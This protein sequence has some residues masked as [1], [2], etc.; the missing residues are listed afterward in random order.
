MDHLVEKMKTTVKRGLILRFVGI[1]GNFIE[2]RMCFQIT[3][4]SSHNIPLYFQK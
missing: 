2:K 1:S 3:A 4:A